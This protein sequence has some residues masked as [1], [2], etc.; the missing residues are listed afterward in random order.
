[1]KELNVTR[2]RQRQNEKFQRTL[3]KI[4]FGFLESRDK[5]SSIKLDE[6]RW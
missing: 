4:V 5:Y 1:M 3:F 6:L 2:A